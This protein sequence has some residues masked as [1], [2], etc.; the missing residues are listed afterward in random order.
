MFTLKKWLHAFVVA[1]SR[2][3]A[4][5]M[6]DRVPMTLLGEGSSAELC[7]AIAQLGVRKLLLVTD[8]M[9]VKV[10]VVEQ[11][12]RALDAAG[13]EWSIYDGV[14]PD[15]T[16]VH[17][18]AGL[19]QLRRERCEAVLAVGGGSS[20]DAAKIIAAMAT[21]DKPLEKLEG[22]FKVRRPPLPLFAVPTTAGTG[23]EVTVVAVVSDPESH[24][25]KFVV[26]PKLLPMMAALDPGLM[27]GLPPAVTAATGMDALTHAVE[28]FLARTA[29]PQTDAY[30]TAAVRLIFRNL[31]LAYRDG[32]NIEARKGMALASYYAG[33]AFTRTSVG[34][35]HAIAHTFGAYYG[36]PHGFANAIALPHVLEFSKEAAR[37]RLAALADIIG[38][39]RGGDAAKADGFIE[40]VCKLKRE[41]DIPATLE[42][43]KRDD[44][45]AIAK[46]A[47]AEAHLNYPVPRYMRQAECEELLARMVD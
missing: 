8:A 6:P 11:V 15:P 22:W 25:K 46:Q 43:L 38:V 23:S 45:A 35:V 2:L 18:A 47:L 30:A 39:E 7:N 41:I 27:K 29:N 14:E 21:N 16:S 42:A 12:T 10:R 40:A 9:L 13:C 20:M 28:A 24:T 36:T 44:V 26:D 33:V 19:S 37:E 5:L 32:S 1:V 17:V 3:F 34:Y 4:G 31:G